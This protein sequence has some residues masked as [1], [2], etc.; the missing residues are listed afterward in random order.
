MDPN[1]QSCASFELQNAFGTRDLYVKF[2]VRDSNDITGPFGYYVDFDA[3]ARE[4]EKRDL[5]GFPPVLCNSIFGTRSCN[6]DYRLSLYRFV[7]RSVEY[8][9]DP[10]FKHKAEIN[11]P[12]GSDVV[13]SGFLQIIQVPSSA[14]TLFVKLIYRGWNKEAG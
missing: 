13:S 10:N 3:Y 7:L 1:W 14:R 5:A 2:S 12:E 6:W 9:F 8:S 11:I 4:Q